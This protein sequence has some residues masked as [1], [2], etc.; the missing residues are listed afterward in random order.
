MFL[1]TFPPAWVTRVWML[2]FT[3]YEN[4]QKCLITK[5][6]KKKINFTNFVNFLIFVNFMMFGLRSQ[7][8]EIR[9]FLGI[10]NHCVLFYFS[11]FSALFSVFVGFS[12]QDFFHVMFVLLF[13]L[14][15]PQQHVHFWEQ[16]SKDQQN[17][18]H[19]CAN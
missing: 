17:S 4:Y 6:W 11:L 15:F 5:K 19:N 1:K 14:Q 3:V 7:C 2:Y 12:Y 10:F 16:W 9:H 18:R 8:C 13:S